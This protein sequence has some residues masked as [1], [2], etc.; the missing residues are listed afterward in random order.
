[1]LTL[2][3]PQKHVSGRSSQNGWSELNPKSWT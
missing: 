3:A 2:V 1:M